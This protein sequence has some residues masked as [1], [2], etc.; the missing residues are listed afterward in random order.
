MITTARAAKAGERIIKLIDAGDVTP[1]YL[2]RIVDEATGLQ[3][4]E[5]DY[6]AMAAQLLTAMDEKAKLIATCKILMVEG[7]N[8]TVRDMARIVISD[9]EAS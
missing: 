1:N 2:A 6:A 4:L 7:S 8:G 5:S 9:I 3:E